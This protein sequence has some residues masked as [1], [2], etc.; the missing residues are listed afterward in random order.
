MTN[1]A[2]GAPGRHARLPGVRGPDRCGRQ[3][4]DWPSAC[5]PSSGRATSRRR[6]KRRRS[7]TSATRRRRFANEEA[8]AAALR[9]AG[10]V[11]SGSRRVGQ[12]EFLAAEAARADEPA[13]RRLLQ[14]PTRQKAAKSP[15]TR[16]IAVATASPD[17]G[18][19]AARRLAHAA[20]AGR[21]RPAKILV[22]GDPMSASSSTRATSRPWPGPRASLGR[23]GSRP[24][25]PGPRRLLCG[26]PRTQRRSWT[27]TRARRRGRLDWS[28]ETA[29][30]LGC[31]GGGDK[32]GKLV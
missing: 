10:G 4:A 27:W 15:P 32:Q 9:G 29:K 25:A 21:G 11:R 7:K 23:R 20:A 31:G 13:R 5:W 28:G 16:A 18:S 26:T 19:F 1:L 24:A 2:G 12:G 22:A 30:T 8:V 14:A 6:W 17:H 3:A